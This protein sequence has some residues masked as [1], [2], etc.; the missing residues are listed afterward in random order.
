MVVLAIFYIQVS[1]CKTRFDAA[2]T[3]RAR[4]RRAYR[5]QK[6]VGSRTHIA[7]L[8]RTTDLLQGSVSRGSLIGNFR[9]DSS[10]A[11]CLAAPTKPRN[12]QVT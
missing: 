10:A 4:A 8:K 7:F 1:L 2:K 11:F 5:R 3:R 12:P 9:F 6:C